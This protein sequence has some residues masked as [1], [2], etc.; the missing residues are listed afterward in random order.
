MVTT[1]VNYLPAEINNLVFRARYGPGTR[2]MNE[3]WDN[4]ILLDACR[5]DMFADRINLDGELQSRISLGST[6]EEFLERNFGDGTF[7]DTVY[8]NTNPYLP[9]LGLDDGT[10]HAVIDLLEEWDPESQ[11]VHPETVV[12]AAR[13]AHAEFPNRSSVEVST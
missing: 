2:V 9:R 13:D 11:T 5:Y 7:H 12:Q 1:A 4:L 8:I 6:S 10:F 3:D